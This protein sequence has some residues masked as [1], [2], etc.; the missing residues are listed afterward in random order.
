[1]YK[2]ILKC[3]FLIFMY[4]HFYIHILVKIVTKVI[5]LRAYHGP[6]QFPFLT[7]QNELSKISGPVVNAIFVCT[8]RMYPEQR[9]HQHP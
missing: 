1:M 2:F 4:L 3:I 6:K 7:L 5:C 9:T 8:Y